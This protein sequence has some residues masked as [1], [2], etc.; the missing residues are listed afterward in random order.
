MPGWDKGFK[1]GLT[2]YGDTEFS[3]F[4]RK[5]FLKSMGYSEDALDRPIIGITN[6]ASAYNSCHGNVPQLVE[7][8][9]RG[10]AMA[11]GL[12][13]EFPVMSLHESFAWPTSMYLRN[14]MAMEVEEMIR[15]QPMDA[16]V[17]VGGCDKTVPALLMGGISAGKPMI[18]EVTGPMLTGHH[19]GDRV[20][21]CTD[22]RRYW[23]SYRAGEIDEAEIVDVS[24]QLGPTVGTCMVMGTASTMALCSEAM[25]AMLPGGAATPAV[26][27]ARFR[28]AELTGSRAVGVA[29]ENMTPSNLFDAASIR[30]SFRTLMAIGGSTNAVVHLTAIARRLGVDISLDEIDQIGR[31]VPMIVDLKPSGQFYMQELEAAGGFPAIRNALGDY[32]ELDAKTVG[33][34]THREL[35]DAG[36]VA[37]IGV[38][39]SLQT[40]IYGGGA[41]AVLKGNL[42][43]DGAVIKESAADRDLVQHEG[44][45][46]IFDGL[47]DLMARIDSDDLDVSADDILVLRG[48]GPRGAPGMPEAG[49][50]PIPRK[51][52]RQGVKDMVRI[53]D[54]RMS[55]TAYGT[56]VLHVAPEAAVG[57]PLAKLRNGDR[58]RIDCPNR[59]LDAVADDDFD[60]RPVSFMPPY[61]APTNGYAHLFDREVLQA[62]EG[63]DFRFLAG[64]REH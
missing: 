48:I 49:Y 31:D 17:L 9:K 44:R 2:Q 27:S 12:A 18:L 56:I 52:A 40:P 1:E 25:G 5:V 43:P 37:P 23:A 42:A 64:T 22:C 8:I 30:N 16:V 54:G 29:K 34:Q 35:L 55:G 33:G 57:G 46:V 36:S 61:T 53:S 10:V 3:L 45:A 14:L 24:A 28:H 4:L 59:R 7:S 60:A 47:E 63:C 62:D 13:F 20:G 21:A 11:G 15:A 32:L 51:L 39:R 6:T 58:I 41:I 19:R 50:I 38:I 26:Y